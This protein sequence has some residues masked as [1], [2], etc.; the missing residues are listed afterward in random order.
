[1]REYGYA[2]A[3]IGWVDDAEMFYRKVVGAEFIKG[4]EPENSIYCNMIEM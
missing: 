3:I 1:M 4:G 2:Y